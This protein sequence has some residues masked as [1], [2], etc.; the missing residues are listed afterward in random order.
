MEVVSEEPA[1]GEETF[2][3]Q[4]ALEE[5]LIAAYYADEKEPL[6]AALAQ[7]HVLL[8]RVAAETDESMTLPTMEHE[9]RSYVPVFTSQAQ[10]ERGAPE[11]AEWSQVVMGQLAAEWPA[12]I[13][14]LL[15]PGGQLGATLD[16]ADIRALAPSEGLTI[17]AGSDLRVGVPAE[18][19][20]ELRQ[21]VDRWAS[22][23]PDVV[24]VHRALVQIDRDQPKLFLG[25]EVAPGAD[26]GDAVG[27]CSAH[28][29]GVAVMALEP[30]A[31]DPV[32]NF[33]RGRDDP[34]FRR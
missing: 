6:L 31:D 10:A 19:P 29:R 4:N 14:V 25:I 17:P 3:A 30:D 20:E 34:L 13:G 11:Q 2:D 15:N 28:I 21:A 24:A 32:T 7:H 22:E 26:A 23:R 18:E 27:S 5:A 33:M 16:G 9:G 8:P 12:E 1:P